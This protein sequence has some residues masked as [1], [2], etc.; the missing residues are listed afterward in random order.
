MHIETKQLPRSLQAALVGVGYGRRDIALRARDSYCLQQGS[1]KGG[2][3]FVVA[4][5]ITTGQRQATHGSWGGANMFNPQN[6]VDLDTTK[7]PLPPGFA[8]IEGSE[9]GGR[10]V[11][12]TI[13]V[14]PDNLAK[15]LPAAPSV[16]L[17]KQDKNALNIIGGIKSGYRANEFSRA[18]LGPYGPDNPH[19]VKLVELGFL[20]VNRAGAISITTAG[21]N[22][23]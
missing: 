20:K 8:I 14:H 10:P 16:E 7:R 21:R 3:A 18:G 4:V 15:L 6:H 22:A 1:G 11:Y 23:R 19:V 13:S 2:R 9:G 12:A 5:N 17:S